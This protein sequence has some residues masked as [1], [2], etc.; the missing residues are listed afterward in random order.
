MSVLLCDSNC[1]L[2]HTRAKELGLEYI[3]MPYLYGGV[4][5]GYDLGEKT[6]FKKFYDAVR[7][8]TVPK[9]MALNPENYKE[10]L[11]PYFKAGE[12]V[13]YISFSHEMSGTFAQLDVALEE[14]K[15]EFPERKCTVFNT[16]SICLGAGIQVEA[17]SELKQN[18]ASD[19]E[20]LAFLKDFTN[21][22]A[23][24][25]VVDDLMHLKRGGRLSAGAAV[26]GT[27]LSIKPML[28]VNEKGGLNVLEKVMG[29]KKAV[30]ALADKVVKG[31][32]GTEYN[33]YVLDADCKEDGDELAEKIKAARPDAKIVRQTVGPVIG[34]HCGPDTLG[35]IFIA[36]ER[37]VKLK[38]D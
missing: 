22:V 38:V 14:L 33:V 23:I 13:L 30:R 34:S 20:I 25:F 29:R 24:Y 37:P 1:E 7:G 28:T 21:R 10:I 27:L 6:D 35:V 16:N 26:A 11:T 18:G 12:D 8:G 19:E 15:K 36:N 2:W 17:A 3:S 5:Y 32:T 9:T 31:L 4:E